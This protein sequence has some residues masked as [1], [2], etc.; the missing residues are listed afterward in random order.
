MADTIIHSVFFVELR[1]R[2]L[3]RDRFCCRGWGKRSTLVIDDFLSRGIHS[4]RYGTAPSPE[5]PPLT[6]ILFRYGM[7]PQHVAYIGS[8]TLQYVVSYALN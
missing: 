2:V 3:Q 7:R 4:D 6:P 1:E 8:Q 5:F